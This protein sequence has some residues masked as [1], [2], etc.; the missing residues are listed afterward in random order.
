MRQHTLIKWK[1]GLFGVPCRHRIDFNISG[2]LSMY[3]KNVRQPDLKII[4]IMI[5]IKHFI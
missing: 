4:V 5:N 1:K 3:T 2:Y